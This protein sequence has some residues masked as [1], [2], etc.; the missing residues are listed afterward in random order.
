MSRY[1]VK[2]FYDDGHAEERGYDNFA[3]AIPLIMNVRFSAV[4]FHTVE[5]WDNQ[6][7]LLVGLY[8]AEGIALGP[9][10]T[11]AKVVR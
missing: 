6:S 4:D 2:T 10:Y 7:G 9:S 5:V 3:Q 1:A 11:T 8:K